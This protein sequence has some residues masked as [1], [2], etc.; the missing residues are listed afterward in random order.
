MAGNGTG[1]AAIATPRALREALREA[2]AF[3]TIDDT[4][5]AAKSEVINALQKALDAR[6]QRIVI[7][8]TTVSLVRWFGLL[9]T[10]LCVMIFVDLFVEQRL[11]VCRYS[12]GWS[13]HRLVQRMRVRRG[14]SWTGKEFTGTVVVKPALTWLETC[15]NRVMGRGVV[16]RRM[17]VRRIIAAA[18]MA[19]LG[20]SA[21][22]QPPTPCCQTLDATSVARLGR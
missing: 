9:V 16:L 20:A 21:K 6:R 11:P 17:L 19:T 7:S 5:K 15:D 4:Q 1:Q 14:K 3:A 12:S 10:G 13:G 18:N 8:Q 2:L 22:L